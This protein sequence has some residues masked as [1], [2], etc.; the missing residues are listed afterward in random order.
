MSLPSQVRDPAAQQN[1][2]AIG[3]RFRWGDGDPNGKVVANPGAFYLNGSGGAGNTLWVKESG[4]NTNT[5][6]VAK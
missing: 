5:G 1:F 3:Q 6:W 4:V 2:E